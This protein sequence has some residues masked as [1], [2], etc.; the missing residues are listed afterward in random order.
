MSV[1]SYLVNDIVNK[2][3]TEFIVLLENPLYSYGRFDYLMEQTGEC[4]IEGV[5]ISQN[6]IFKIQKFYNNT[7]DYNKSK[8]L[9]L[10][11]NNIENVYKVE[12][13]INDYETAK[14]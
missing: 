3:F 7:N 2:S 5:S 6:T 10:I 12:N 13:I 4:I 9:N 8:I 1:L 14:G 11:N